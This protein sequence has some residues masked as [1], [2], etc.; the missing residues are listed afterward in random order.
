MHCG[1]WFLYCIGALDLLEP[2]AFSVVMPA[3]LCVLVGGGAGG[4]LVVVAFVRVCC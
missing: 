4:Y 1:K 2:L 3:A